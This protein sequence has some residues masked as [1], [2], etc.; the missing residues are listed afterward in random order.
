MQLWL[1]GFWS[2]PSASQTI[3]QTAHVLDYWNRCHIG[4]QMTI[5]GE[6]KSQEG[7]YFSY[8]YSVSVEAFKH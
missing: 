6:S 8:F 1:A 4:L 7:G 5:E 3:G 2:F